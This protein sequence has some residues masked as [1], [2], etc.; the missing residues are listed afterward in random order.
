M[1]LGNEKAIKYGS[2]ITIQHVSERS[3]IL[4]SDGYVDMNIYF[5]KP[6]RVPNQCLQRGLFIVFPPFTNETKVITDSMCFQVEDDH[7][8]CHEPRS[9]LRKAHLIS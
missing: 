2:V 8:L 9:D 7:L 5:S 3:G 1:R 6:K 4:L